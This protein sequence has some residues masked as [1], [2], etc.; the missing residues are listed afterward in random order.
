MTDEERTVAEQR[1]L[2]R[3]ARVRALIAGARRAVADSQGPVV[4]ASLPVSGPAD[5]SDGCDYPA[6]PHTVE[7]TPAD[8]LEPQEGVG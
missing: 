8:S 6:D 5:P 4:A 2:E 7:E 3:A 1:A